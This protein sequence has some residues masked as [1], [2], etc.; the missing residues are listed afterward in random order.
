MGKTKIQ[1]HERTILRQIYAPDGLWR[2]IP[3]AEQYKQ[4]EKFHMHL[5]KD[6]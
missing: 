6:E 3:T 5:G 2:R 4:T 1:K